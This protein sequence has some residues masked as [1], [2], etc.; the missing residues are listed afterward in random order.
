MHMVTPLF[1]LTCSVYFSKLHYM[2]DESRLVEE[3][4]SRY[5]SY[6]KLSRPVLNSSTTVDV[7]FELWLVEISDFDE[8]K[9]KLTTQLWKKQVGVETVRQCKRT[10]LYVHH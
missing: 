7:Q 5:Q 10:R 3:L 6:R 1:W 8:K 4:M 2:S 9:Q